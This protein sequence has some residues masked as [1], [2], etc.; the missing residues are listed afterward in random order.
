MIKGRPIKKLRMSI[1]E[2]INSEDQKE[3][4]TRTR[5]GTTKKMRN[6][7]RKN[8]KEQQQPT[9]NLKKKRMDSSQFI[10]S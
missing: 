1:L 5:S 10:D 9:S 3:P 8:K 6:H 2:I 7:P 4:V